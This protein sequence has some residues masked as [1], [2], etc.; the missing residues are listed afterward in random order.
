MSRRYWRMATACAGVTVGEFA[1]AEDM[2][3]KEDAEISRDAAR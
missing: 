2:E 3:K 1:G